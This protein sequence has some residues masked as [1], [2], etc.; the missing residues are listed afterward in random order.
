[1]PRPINA[2]IHLQALSHNLSQARARAP[3]SKVWAVVKANAYGHGIEHV[4]PA[5]SQ[6]DGFALLD[7]E[8]ASLLRKLGWKKPILLLEGT[9]APADM[10]FCE[11]LDIWHTIHTETQLRWLESRHSSYKHHVFLKLNAGMNRLGFKPQAYAQAWNRL[12]ALPHV[13]S[14]TPMMH[15]SDADGSRFGQSG[16]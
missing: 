7:L 9:F 12:Q 10:A 1:M 2:R 5:L 14:I 11:A 15:F 3:S 4:Y 6:A 13:A 16:I 8:E